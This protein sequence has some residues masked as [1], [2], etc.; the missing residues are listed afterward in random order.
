MGVWVEGDGGG[1]EGDV[2]LFLE[3]FFFG[4]FFS[5][6]VFPAGKRGAIT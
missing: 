4:P 3:T 5:D 2:L 6:S 1:G